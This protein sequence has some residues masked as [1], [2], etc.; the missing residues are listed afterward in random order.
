MNE[1]MTFQVSEHTDD[2]IA[3]RFGSG[4]FYTFDTT[5]EPTL[6]GPFASQEIA[7]AAALQAIEEALADRVSEALGLWVI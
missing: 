1:T 5:K 6:V 2:V 7:E 3:Q 4:W